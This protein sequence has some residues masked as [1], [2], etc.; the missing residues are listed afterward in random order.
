MGADRQTST[1]SQQYT[2]TD[3]EKQLNQL[4]LGQAQAFDPIQRQ[5][6][7]NGGNLVNN[8]LTGQALPGYLNQLPGGITPD[9]TQ[10]IVND[11]L[12]DLYPQFQKSGILDS[13]VAAQIAG[14]TSADIRQNSAQFNLQNLQQ[15]L[16]L[17]VGGQA[18]VQQPSVSTSQALGGRL[19][20]LASSS[21]T[22]ST[23]GMNPFLK[24][25]QTSLGSSLGSG[26]FGSS[27]SGGAGGGGA[28]GFA[29]FF[30]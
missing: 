8:L 26:S 30:A 11:S 12:N 22:T 25:F 5:L 28:G 13:G 1:Q 16:N 24:S 14:R 19:A 6:N 21:G 10:G 15:L 4:Q 18:Q 29:K 23:I 7:N 27:G 17:G 20:G 2:P 3:E 9:V